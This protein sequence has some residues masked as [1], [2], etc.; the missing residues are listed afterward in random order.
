[1][2]RR[3][4]GTFHSSV[5]TVPRSTGGDGGCRRH[6]NGVRQ[7]VPVSVLASGS[8]AKLV[9]VAR[10]RRHRRRPARHRACPTNHARSAHHATSV[11]VPTL[12]ALD[13]GAPRMRTVSAAARAVRRRRNSNASRRHCRRLRQ[14][15]R[16]R[17]LL[18][19][20]SAGG[21]R[22]GRP[23]RERR[24]RSIG[25]TTG[26]PLTAVRDRR[27]R[28]REHIAAGAR[29]G[30]RR[31]GRRPRAFRAQ[32]STAGTPLPRRRHNRRR[33]TILAVLE[34]NLVDGHRE[35]AAAKVRAVQVS[36]GANAA[37]A[38]GAAG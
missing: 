21:A 25:T 28:L 24:R 6:G 5:T 27:G 19:P 12:N 32:S 20:S 16:P 36:A 2:P 38:G 1:M 17:L 37:V 31:R 14:R 9:C 10:Q 35:G 34:I 26:R 15:R 23:A 30:R 18:L 7:R 4:N 13:R 3:R 8:G 29:P 33:V 11:N 22:R